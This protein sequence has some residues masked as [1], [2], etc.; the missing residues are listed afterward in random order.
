MRPGYAGEGQRGGRLVDPFVSLDP[1]SRV[2]ALFM[3]LV[4]SILS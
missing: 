3:T 2:V 1:P 4:V